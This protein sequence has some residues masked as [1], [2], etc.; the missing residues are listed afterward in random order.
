[1]YGFCLEF[2]VSATRVLNPKMAIR[3]LGCVVA[4]LVLCSASKEVPGKRTLILVDN[5]SI[6]ETHSVFFK[7]LRGNLSCTILIEV[8]ALVKRRLHDT[9]LYALGKHAIRSEHF[10]CYRSQKSAY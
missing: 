8:G 1:M 9:S 6:R 3:L 4:F 5:W 7:S 10:W 2:A